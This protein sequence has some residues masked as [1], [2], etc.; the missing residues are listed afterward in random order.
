MSKFRS[1]LKEF[2]NIAFHLEA[3]KRNPEAALASFIIFWAGAV[4]LIAVNWKIFL[5]M[6]L[7]LWGSN[8][9]EW[10]KRN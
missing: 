9:N 5:G 8:I 3:Q 2:A 10:I 1:K 7:M 6:F 4:I